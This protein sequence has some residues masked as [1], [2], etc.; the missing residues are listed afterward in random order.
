MPF[1]QPMMEHMRF[2]GFSDM[3]K[4]DAEEGLQLNF[5]ADPVWLS[6]IL[7]GGSEEKQKAGCPPV[8]MQ[9]IS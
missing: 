4:D 9:H 6:W 5:V 2:L 3:T 7:I 8:C 1:W